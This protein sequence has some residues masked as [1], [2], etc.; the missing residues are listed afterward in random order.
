M[1]E[2]EDI[3]NVYIDITPRINNT[4][5][6]DFNNAK[7]IRK[8]KKFNSFSSEKTL[9][10]FSEKHVNFAKIEIVRIENYKK[11]NRT[12]KYKYHIDKSEKKCNIF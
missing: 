4:A 12:I 3:S 11:Y 6:F 9:S 1:S 10:S 8:T 7:K 5:H 2:K